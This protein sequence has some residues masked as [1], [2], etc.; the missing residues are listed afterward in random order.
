MDIIFIL[1]AYFSNL[2]GEEIHYEQVGRFSTI[3][4]CITGAKLLKSQ[5]YAT[6]LSGEVYLDEDNVAGPNY[7]CMA[8][9]DR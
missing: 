7:I 1:L 4:E 9:F 2:E 5:K 3:E 6:V 8:A